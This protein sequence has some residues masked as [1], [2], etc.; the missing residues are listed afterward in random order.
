ML[1]S[2][3]ARLAR[4]EIRAKI[5]A[6]GMGEIYLAIDTRRHRSVARAIRR[7]VVDRS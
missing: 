7:S 2:A 4:Y 1:L 6:G 3:G 5:G